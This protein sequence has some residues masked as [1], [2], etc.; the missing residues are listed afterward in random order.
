MGIA[1]LLTEHPLYDLEKV[2]EFMSELVE[3]IQAI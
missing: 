3:I 1:H 2:N